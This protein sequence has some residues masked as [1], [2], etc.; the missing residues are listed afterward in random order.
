MCR[1]TYVISLETERSGTV[2]IRAGVVPEPGILQADVTVKENNTLA[3]L[4]TVNIETRTS[5]LSFSKF[6]F[7]ITA[8]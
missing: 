3:R 4:V 6:M 2:I 7:G 1:G 5:Y 8:C